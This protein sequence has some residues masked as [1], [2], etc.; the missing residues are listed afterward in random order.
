[1]AFE[2][3]ADP[4]GYAIRVSG[5]IDVTTAALVAEAIDT[6]PAAAGRTVAL[7]YSQVTF[8]GAEGL[9]LAAA[10]CRGG[11]VTVGAPDRIRRLFVA[12]GLGE[13]LAPTSSEVAA[14]PIGEC[15]GGWDIAPDH[16]TGAAAK[17]RA[18]MITGFRALPV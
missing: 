8:C 3:I 13:L 11:Q 18:R 12:C 14:A 10:A 1:V 15:L 6:L 5:D 9:N 17:T 7:D 16:P 2:V 4:V